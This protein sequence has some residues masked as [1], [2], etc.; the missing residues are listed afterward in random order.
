MTFWEL[1]SPSN[2]KLRAE[3]TEDAVHLET[4]ICPA[5]PGHQRGGR[6]IGQLSVDLP[7]DFER[8]FIWT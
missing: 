2:Q 5:N 8:D 3:W 4:V 6:R 1:V 7:L